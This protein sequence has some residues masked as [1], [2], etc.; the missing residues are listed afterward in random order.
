MAMIERICKY[1]GKP[2]KA[3]PDVIKRGYGNFCSKSCSLYNRP[4]PTLIER[5]WKYVEKSH[6]CWHWKGGKDWDRYGIFSSSIKAHRFSYK[7][8]N[9]EI[10][11]GLSVLH[12]CDN[13]SCVNPEHLFLG[14]HRDNMKDRYNKNRQAKG[15]SNGNSKL[16]E[17]DVLEIKRLKGV[18]TL[19]EIGKIYSV[20][21]SVIGNIFNNKIWKHIL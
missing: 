11:K 19:K 16:T 7:L 3:R 12:S 1:C 9:G 13:P 14:T 2:F 17:K 21:L 5:F 15:E 4:Q 18:M 10:P 8:H 20:D 6:G